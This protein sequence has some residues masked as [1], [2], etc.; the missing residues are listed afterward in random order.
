MQWAE[1]R[2]DALRAFDRVGSGG[3][4]VLGREGREFEQALAK[5]WGLDHAAGV[6]SGMDAIEIALRVLGCSPGD[7]VLTTPLSAFA[8]TLAI[9]RTG[10]IPVFA[11]TDSRGLI[12]LARC[13]E[14]LRTKPGIRYFVPVHLYGHSLDVPELRNLREDFGL[15]IVEDCAQSIG[16]DFRGEVPG[17]AGQLAATSFYPTKNLGAMGD[18]G[19]ILT[20][21]ASLDARVR[22]LRDYGQTAKY[23]H[24]YLGSN[25]RLD[26]VQAAFLLDACLP[27]FEKWTRR[28]REIAGA[29]LD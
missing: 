25:S 28:R 14:L 5:L 15:K 29:Y 17:S 11:D 27:R 18:G 3:Q 24:E 23:R 9:I 10:A 21:D 16:A 4:F 7:R 12:D 1:I 26:E 19:A 22:A 8:T 20:R 2:E 13:R 6:A